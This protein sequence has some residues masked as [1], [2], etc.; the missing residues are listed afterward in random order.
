MA[1]KLISITYIIHDKNGIPGND[2]IAHVIEPSI[3]RHFTITVPEEPLEP[4]AYWP[5]ASLTLLGVEWE[6]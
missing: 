2:E 3:L 5:S 1:K 6:D 4:G